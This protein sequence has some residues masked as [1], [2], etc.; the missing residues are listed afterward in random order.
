MITDDTLDETISN[1]VVSFTGQYQIKYVAAHMSWE[2]NML[3]KAVH[4]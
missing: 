4:L 2:Q 1:K 3:T